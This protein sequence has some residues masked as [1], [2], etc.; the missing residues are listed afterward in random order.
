MGG[1][2][3][4][5]GGGEVRKRERQ[6]DEKRERGLGGGLLLRKRKGPFFRGALFGVSKR[7][8]ANTCLRTWQ[9]KSERMTDQIRKK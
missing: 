8:A 4:R 3:E 5:E 2:R 6:K 7:L 9:T 1:E